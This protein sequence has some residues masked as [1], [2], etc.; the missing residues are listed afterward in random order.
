MPSPCADVTGAGA[1]RSEVTVGGALGTWAGI[2]E[3]EQPTTQ[4]DPV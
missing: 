1:Q 2:P 4:H 3:A